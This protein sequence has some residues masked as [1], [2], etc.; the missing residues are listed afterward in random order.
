[1]LSLYLLIVFALSWP[2]Q[3]AFALWGNDPT[4]GYL[5]SS[6]SMAMVTVGTFIAG[7]WV[8]ETGPRFLS[9]AQSIYAGI[10]RNEKIT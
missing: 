7:R 2:P 6:L 10:Q 1:L 8:F 5:L 3:I 4:S 9:K